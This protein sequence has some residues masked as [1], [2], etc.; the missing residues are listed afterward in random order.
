[1]NHAQHKLWEIFAPVLERVS[2]ARTLATDGHREEIRELFAEIYRNEF[3][4]RRDVS[5]FLLFLSFAMDA[6][7]LLIKRDRRQ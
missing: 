2:E 6:A 1:M 5:D 4:D 3:Q 7:D